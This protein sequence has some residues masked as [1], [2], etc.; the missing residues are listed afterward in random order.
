MPE[1]LMP[2]FLRPSRVHLPTCWLASVLA[3]V[4]M[5]LAAGPVALASN[6]PAV[7]P[8]AAAAPPPV[9]LD[10]DLGRPQGAAIASAH[11]EATAAGMAVLRA[12]GNAFD[13]AVAVS[14]TLGLV[15]P[16]SSGL[17]GGGFFLLRRASDGQVVFIDARERAPLAATR[18]M[19]LDPA[20]GKPK[21]RATIDGALAAAIPGQPA[22]LVHVAENFGRLPLRESLAPAIRLAERGWRFGEKN[23][24]MLGWRKDAVRADPGAA[25]LFL[26]DGEAPRLGAR[27]RNPDYAATLRLLAEHGHDGFYRGPMAERLVEAVRAAGGIWT[28]EDLARYHVVER[29]PL[30]F[31][32]RGKTIVTAPPPSSGGIALAQ[33]LQILDGFNWAAKTPPQRLHLR[34]EAMRRAYRDRALYLGDPDF[35]AV[36]VERLMHPAYAAGLRAAIHPLRATPSALLPGI[37]T[38]A[39]GADTT[40]FSIVDAEGNLAAVTQ[41]VNL[42][43]GNAMVVP[44][45]GFLLNN[46]MD[47]FS[48]KPGV[49]NAFGLVGQEANAIEPGKR[50][51]SSMTPTFVI[52]P[53][54]VA[55]I[56]TPGGSR[57][58]S[59]VIQATLDFGAGAD[60][61]AIVTAPRL[62][63]QYLP[64]QV[65][66]EPGSLNA[67]TRAAL[68]AKGHA[69]KEEPRS[70]G[71]MQVVIWHRADGRTEA[72]T[73][74]RWE[75]VGKGATSGE[76]GIFR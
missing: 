25:A 23:L 44:G 5:P 53:E 1:G 66:I 18:D 7:A 73:D 76:G 31:Q 21:P 41:T 11:A 40:H 58:I 65:S 19:F 10:A 63:H 17:G 69:V 30:V 8:P 37:A 59:M 47:D 55:V 75:A 3:L 16:E 51:L 42:P 64:D 45:T 24:A 4:A 22:A 43:F 72:G 57:I 74:P 49:P 27:M 70:W 68:E 6:L 33:T 62:H 61:R 50:P 67:A 39:E 60:A 12:G 38:L 36:P 71:N 28:L 48:I 2:R 13:A 29:R 14:A 52:G 15:E 26:V 34:I 54:R 56:G 35:F 46:E 9:T 32:H 20:T